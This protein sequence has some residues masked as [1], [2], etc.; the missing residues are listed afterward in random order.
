M[1]PLLF[2]PALALPLGALAQELEPRAYSN[3]PIGTSFAIA[4]YTR[5]SGPVLLDPSLVAVNINARVNAYTLGYARFFS[6]FGRT[7]SVSVAVPYIES[8]L[9]GEVVDA[10]TDVHRAGFGDTHLR[11]AINLFGHPA[12]T[13]AEFVQRP[14][15]FSGGASLSVIA[16]TGQ[17]EPTRFINIGTNRWA[18]KPDFGISYPIGRWF[19]E[20]AAGVWLFTDNDEVL[21]GKH[22]SQAPLWVYQLHAGYSFRPGLWLAADYGYYTGG[23]TTL[24]GV[25]K[26]D[27]QR[28]SRVG[29]ALSLPI[30]HGWSGKLAWSKGTAVR[31]GGDYSMASI[32]VQY[33]WFD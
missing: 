7:A 18:F 26:D 16:P 33:R 23:N 31:V 3:A 13:P 5:I 14:E 29:L 24:D 28:N 8:D 11:G 12:L 25:A 6:M 2:L 1:R 21:G 4:S 32:T 9:H 20:A 10:T 30:G 22:R 27:A 19:T 17:Y 15:V